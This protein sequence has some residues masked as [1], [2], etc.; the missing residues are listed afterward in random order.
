[1]GTEFQKV[2]AELLK[3][4]YGKTISYKEL[5]LR[6]KNPKAVR[7]VGTA[8]GKN[9][10]CLLIPCHRVIAYDGKLGGYSAGIKIKESLL[11]LEGKD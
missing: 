10:I 2:W 5:A 3:I 8:N 6:I 11:S 7:A 4:P 9:P 1:M